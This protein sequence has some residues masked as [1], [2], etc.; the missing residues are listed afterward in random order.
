MW[1]AVCPCDGLATQCGPRFSVWFQTSG[2][3]YTLP[4]L[5][6]TCTAAEFAS[7]IT[8]IIYMVCIQELLFLHRMK[9]VM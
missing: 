4:K 8:F 9:F 5:T 7:K 6:A 3:H 2:L 1:V